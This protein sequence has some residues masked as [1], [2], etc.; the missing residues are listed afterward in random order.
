MF[1]NVKLPFGLSDVFEV[2]TDLLSLLD[3]WILLGI[4]FVLAIVI[5]GV[6]YSV[7][8]HSKQQQLEKRRSAAIQSMLYDRPVKTLDVEWKVGK[9]GG[10]EGR[11]VYGIGKGRRG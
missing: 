4:G 10:L 9:N 5:I 7:I 2:V 8:E 3:S 1:D 11:E 6:L